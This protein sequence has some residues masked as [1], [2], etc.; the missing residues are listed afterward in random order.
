MIYLK[1][2]EAAQK[3]IGLRKEQLAEAQVVTAPMGNWYTDAAK[4]FHG[5]A[6]PVAGAARR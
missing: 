2:T 4:H 5:R 6:E 1:C 3:A